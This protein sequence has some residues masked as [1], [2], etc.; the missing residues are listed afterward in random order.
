MAQSRKPMTIE[1]RTVKTAIH[2]ASVMPPRLSNILA[3]S[4]EQRV[5]MPLL[6]IWNRR[7]K[8][9]Q[10]GE[11]YKMREQNGFVCVR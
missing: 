6:Q 1:V 5:A 10:E 3:E 9:K 4:G 7:S 2:T 8:N 11:R